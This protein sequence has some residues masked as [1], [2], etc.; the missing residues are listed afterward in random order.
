MKRITCQ[1]LN[2]N[3]YATVEKIVKSILDFTIFDYILIVDNA[4]TDNSLKMLKNKYRQNQKIKIISTGRNGGYGYGNNF[5]INYAY[6][7]L[8]SEYI[9]VTNPD[10]L[11]SQTTISEMV[12]VIKQ[13]NAAIVSAVQF[14]NGEPI[15]DK[16]WKVPT[17]LEWTLSETKRW[18]KRA[19]KKYHYTDEFF[20]E[21]I[22]QVECV[23]GAMFLINAQDFLEVGGYDESMFL[24]GEETT[25]GLKFKQ[26][27]FKTY[28]INNI[29]YD[30][31][32]SASIN[33][34]FPHVLQQIKILHKSKLYFYKRYLKL[35]KFKY[36]FNKLIL[37]TLILK[38]SISLPI[39]KL[40]KDK[41]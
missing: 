38:L 32:H 31:E 18:G 14:V 7:K 19:F 20:K 4:S 40:I 17:A 9:V 39:H 16:A 36:L 41:S 21:K 25:L 12:K 23:P 26:R 15:K 1:I 13:K 33:K 24:Y 2:F 22:S 11:F 10:V 3:D 28:L 30:H 5:G 37:S 34:T 35:N 6:K 29:K 8:K 27:G